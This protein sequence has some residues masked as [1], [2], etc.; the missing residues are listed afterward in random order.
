MCAIAGSFNVSRE[1]VDAALQNMRHRG[2]DYSDAVILEKFVFGHNLLALRDDVKVSRQPVY[3][4]SGR[5]IITMNGEL[6]DLR[7]IQARLRAEVQVSGDW[8]GRYLAEA[9][10][11]L[12][13]EILCELTGSF[14]LAAYNTETKI[15]YLYRDASGQRPL[16]YSAHSA[17]LLWASEL[18]PF[19]TGANGSNT[20]SVLDTEH[21][22]TASAVGFSFGSDTIIK[23]VKRVRPGELLIFNSRSGVIES[24]V[25]K[26]HIPQVMPGSYSRDIRAEIIRESVIKTVMDYS[27]TNQDTCLNLSGGMDSGIVLHALAEAGKKPVCFTMRY[28]ECDEKYNRDALLAS[29]IARFYGVE[30]RVIDFGPMDYLQEMENACAALGSPTFNASIPAYYWM[31]AAQSTSPEGFK[32]VFTG[33][34]GDEVFGGY[35]VY[36]ENARKFRIATRLPSPLR[37][38]YLRFAQAKTCGEL[39]NDLQSWWL[40]YRRLDTPVYL[41]SARDF[42]KVKDAVREYASDLGLV[43]PSEDTSKFAI[44]NLMKVDRASWL[45]EES[46]YRADKFYMARSIETRS[47]LADPRLAEYMDHLQLEADYF[48]DGKNKSLY[49]DAFAPVLCSDITENKVKSGWGAPIKSDWFC[50]DIVVAWTK[51]IEKMSL[52]FESEFAKHNF[53]DFSKF[54]KSL[55]FLYSLSVIA[56]RHG[57]N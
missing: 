31:A 34:G 52:A 5:W 38:L 37:G 51:S 3:S 33:D 43:D 6:F 16:F 15:L 57:G 24:E 29:K 20:D 42:E 41:K 21:L 39:H 35:S 18:S 32:V 9:L 1:W 19:I 25:Q 54:D 36:E 2:P 30:L 12:G 17:G 13:P 40:N 44:Q 23:T 10:D 47:P 27:E 46:F 7:S 49:R 4:N 26:R 45:A 48:S 50:G 53:S 11:V 8:D 14:A 56:G 22:R 28:L 55:F